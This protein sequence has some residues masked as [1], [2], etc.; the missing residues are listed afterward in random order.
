MN[1]NLVLKLSHKLSQFRYASK[2]LN[3]YGI[4]PQL[5]NCIAAEWTLEV[6]EGSG[7]IYVV[8]RPSQRRR[9]RLRVGK[10]LVRRQ[11]EPGE[12]DM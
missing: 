8:R 5:T 2:I 3:V 10:Y 7:R 11:I 4:A 6:A 9:V 12:C 1:P